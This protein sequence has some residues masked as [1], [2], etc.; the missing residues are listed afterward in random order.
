MEEFWGWEAL[1][2]FWGFARDFMH[3]ELP[4]INIHQALTDMLSHLQVQYTVQ[5]FI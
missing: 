3:W 1:W 5:A 4:F 2:H